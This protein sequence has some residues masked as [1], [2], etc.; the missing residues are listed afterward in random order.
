MDDYVAAFPRLEERFIV[1]AYVGDPIVVGKDSANGLR[2]LIPITS[3][4]V[5]GGLK[6]HILPGGID[7]HIVRPSGL[8]EISARY[9]IELD[10]GNTVYIENDGIRRV[11]P[12]YAAQAAE[13][14]VIDPEHVY[15]VTVP[16]FEVFD[17][18]LRWLEQSI[19]ICYATRYPDR[20]FLRFCQVV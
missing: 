14:K 18:S 20:V 15:F 9:A 1:E 3:G 13:G 6:G 17:E 19:F 10:D 8:T 7:S 2:R 11:S 5:S 16:R 12:E 4:T